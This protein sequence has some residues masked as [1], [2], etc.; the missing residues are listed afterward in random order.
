RPW[1]SNLRIGLTLEKFSPTAAKAPAGMRW[2]SQSM[3]TEPSAKNSLAYTAQPIAKSRLARGG[4]SAS[5]LERK[6][7]CGGESIN[8]DDNRTASD[9]DTD[10]GRHCPT[11]RCPSSTSY[12]RSDYTRSCNRNNRR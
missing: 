10:R 4:K 9:R 3:I 5:L 2:V 7:N 8:R 6:K 11:N 12:C 1:S